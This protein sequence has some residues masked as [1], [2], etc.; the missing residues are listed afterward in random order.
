MYGAAEATARM[1]YLPWSK[2]ESKIGSAGIAIPGGKFWIEDKK[3][4]LEHLKKLVKLYI[5]E[6][7]SILDMLKIK[8]ILQKVMKTK[9]FLELA[10]SVI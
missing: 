8:V 10:I 3:I 4:E 7:T 2:I 1:S 6:I 5:K 9:I